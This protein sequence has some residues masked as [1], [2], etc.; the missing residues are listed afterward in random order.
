MTSGARRRATAVTT[1][2]QHVAKALGTNYLL[3]TIQMA[4]NAQK[5]SLSAMFECTI[6]PLIVQVPPVQYP[7]ASVVTVSTKV[8]FPPEQVG[9]LQ[10]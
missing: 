6:S 8:H 2:Q 9:F 7:S 4:H 10:L 1:T 5:A 3:A